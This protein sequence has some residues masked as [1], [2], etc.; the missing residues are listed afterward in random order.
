M[1]IDRVE[2][3]LYFDDR[4][5]VTID[6]NGLM[7]TNGLDTTTNTNPLL[8]EEMPVVDGTLLKDSD[9]NILND[10]R[11][12]NTW[13]EVDST[14]RTFSTTWATGRTWTNHT[15]TAGNRILL[16]FSIIA[17]N[18]TD[19][20]NWGGGYAQI[21]Y[22]I[23]GGTA[24]TS[25]GDSGFDLGTMLYLAGAIGSQAQTFFVDIAAVTNATQI[26]FRF[27]HRAYQTGT[28]LYI[29][30]NWAASSNMFTN[31]TIQEIG[32]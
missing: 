24:W 10:G 14:S 16:S 4:R 2:D 20:A 8:L 12:V 19:L 26:R 1:K 30:Q 7:K 27:R 29:N 9:G 15:K 13:Y 28:T 17:R 23:D 5:L 21:D 31:L 18:S 22:S 3:K 32:V 11:V 6:D 25:L